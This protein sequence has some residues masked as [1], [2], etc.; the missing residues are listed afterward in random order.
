MFLYPHTPIVWASDMEK[1][2]IFQISKDLSAVL[3]LIL[4]FAIVV[5][6]FLSNRCPNPGRASSLFDVQNDMPADIRAAHHNSDP[7]LEGFFEFSRSKVS[8]KIR[9]KSRRSID[10]HLVSKLKSLTSSFSFSCSCLVC[11]SYPGARPS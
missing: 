4:S 10:R 5:L 7:K 1:T 9:R 2:R 8:P 6:L 11:A 3:R